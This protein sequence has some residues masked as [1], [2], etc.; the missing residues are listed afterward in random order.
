MMKQAT[1]AALPRDSDSVAEDSLFFQTSRS[2]TIVLN[3][4][5]LNYLLIIQSPTVTEI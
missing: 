1:V 3:K 5:I 4:K 2:K